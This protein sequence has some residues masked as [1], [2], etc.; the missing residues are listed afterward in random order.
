MNDDKFQNR[1]QRYGW[2]KSAVYYERSWG[3]QLQPA[4]DELINMANPQEGDRK[5]VV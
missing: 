3:V 4:L 1:V 5:S 2:D